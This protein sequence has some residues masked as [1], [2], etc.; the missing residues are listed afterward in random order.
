MNRILA[1]SFFLLALAPASFASDAPGRSSPILRFIAE[2][3]ILREV[4]LFTL[5]DERCSRY[6]R[7]GDKDSCSEAV[8]QKITLLDFDV[9]MSEDKRTPVLLNE[10]DTD[11]FV[12]VAFKKDLLR[13]L[14]DQKTKAYLELV[15]TEMTRYLTG[16]K[17]TVPSLWQLS[18][19]FFGTQFD[20]A[21]NLAVLFQ[22]TSAVKLHL[23]YLELS[24]AR[25][26][27]ASFDPN[28]ELLTRTIDT[29][30]MVLDAS[31]ENFQALFYPQEI[32]GKLHR[33]IYHFYVPTY[34]SMLLKKKGVPE[35]FAF[36]A[37]LMLTL[38]YEF[39]TSAQDYRYLLDDPERLSL[40]SRADQW[41][42][43][44]IYG[45]YSG[46]SFGLQRT[47]K[48]VG[49]EALAQAFNVSS[50]KAVGLLTQ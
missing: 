18:L 10:N 6:M 43:G 15:N 37:P 7:A 40:T 24:G 32:Q 46:V 25:G 16:Q 5:I 44:D 33:T 29:M 47:G 49:L 26:S 23:A 45:S 19:E 11:S 35:R 3:R 31:G 27:S 9:L 8:D 34:L 39:V 36:I 21:R 20:A 42:V 1:L 48:M 30:N 2:S 4:G 28:R 12:F 38:T 17:A 14:S 50:A 22:D 13:L 41:T